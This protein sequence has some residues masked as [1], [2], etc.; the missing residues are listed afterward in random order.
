M[1]SKFSSEITV[2]PSD[3]DVNGHVHNSIYLDYIEQARFQQMEHNYHYSMEHFWEQGLSWV[4]K[5]T[6]INYV[7]PIRLKNKIQV[8][9]WVDLWQ[10]SDCNVCFEILL[11]DSGKIAAQG[12]FVFTLISVQ[13]GR[14]VAIPADVVAAFSI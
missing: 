6:Q 2:R 5:S 14:P 12:C 7:R 9:T 11:L 8:V 4:V 10:Q 1:G 3:I 13:T